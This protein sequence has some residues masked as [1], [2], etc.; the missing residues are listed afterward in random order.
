MNRERKILLNVVILVIAL[1]MAGVVCAAPMGTAFTY[2]GRLSDANSPAE[3]LYD[4]EFEVYDALNGGSQQG[5]T[6][7]KDDVDVIDAYF[8]VELDFGADIFTGDARWLEIAVRAGASSDPCDLVTLSPRQELTPTPYALYAKTAG[9][10]GDWTISG[11][12]MYTGAGVTGNVGIGTTNPLSKLSVGGDGV[13]D[14]GVYGV[15]STN[16]VYGSGYIGVYGSGDFAGVYGINSGTGS[17]GYLGYGNYGVYGSGNIALY[18]VGSFGGANCLGSHHG[19]YGKDS[20]SS[21]YGYLGFDNWGGYFNGDGYFSGNVGIGT[22]S[23]SEKLDV[24]GNV[25]INSVYKIAG[26][27]VL[28]TP[29]SN[30]FLGIDAGLSNTAGS[31]NTFAGYEAGYSNTTGLDNTFSGNRAGYYNTTGILNTFSGNLAGY[32]NTAGGYNTFSG[33]R[34]GHSNTTGFRNTFLGYGAG[35]SNTTGDDNVFLGYQAGSNETGSNKLYIDNSSTSTP[36][37]HGDFSTN[38]V[39]IA[40]V[41]TSNAFEVEGTASKTA[42]GDWLA[43]SDARI[44]TDIET[45]TGA[46]QTL[47]K[48]RLVSFKYTDD[49]RAEHTSIDERRY[50]NVIAQEFAEVFPD[51][52][53]SSKEKLPNGDEILQVDAYPLTVY[54]AAAV[55]ELH[56]IV[57]AKDA[58]IAELKTRLDAMEAAISKLISSEQGGQL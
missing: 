26:N 21:S 2:Q 20:D 45:V 36:L 55:Q 27:T 19:V 41:A 40:R 32:S 1:G 4:F 16:G 37:I 56:V 49:Y 8:T 29:G 12:D 22:M 38:R 34:A 57:K 5:S 18:G 47:D 51:Y 53:K 14:T 25:N 42:A 31:Y 46:L 7:G 39:G 48:V 15:G 13:A 44:K 17:Y 3:G 33:S 50:L 43:N 58:E 54:S 10:D 28:S 6:V 30:T 52:V 24:N 11:S 35:Y 9:G 23:P